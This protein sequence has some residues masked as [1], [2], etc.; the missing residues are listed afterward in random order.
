MEAPEHG[1]ID[2]IENA[3]HNQ[4]DSIVEFSCEE[5][6]ELEGMLSLVCLPDGKWSAEA[7]TC[8]STDCHVVAGKRHVLKLCNAVSNL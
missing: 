5:N 4:L 2:F 8:V 7:P 6:Y 3:P 1:S